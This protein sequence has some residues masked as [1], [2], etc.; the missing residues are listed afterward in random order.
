MLSI[1]AIFISTFQTVSDYPYIASVA[2][3]TL[4]LRD[5]ETFHPSNLWQLPSS[6]FLVVHTGNAGKSR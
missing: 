5:K 4:G 1:A 6:A 2:S 3:G